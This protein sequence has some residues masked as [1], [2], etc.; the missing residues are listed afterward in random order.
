MGLEQDEKMEKNKKIM[1]IMPGKLKPINLKTK[2]NPVQNIFI[3]IANNN[4]NNIK[5]EKLRNKKKEIIN[6][7][8]NEINEK[9]E[10]EDEE[11]VK[12]NGNKED[13]IKELK[14]EVDNENTMNDN[15]DI[16]EE[17]KNKM[18]NDVNYWNANENY[19]SE[20]EREELL[21]DL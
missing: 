11:I 17:A 5:L 21:N 18:F 20:E 12:K 10:D 16:E 13:I 4:K 15:N 3:N 6:M 2:S 7:F 1:Y 19:L 9:N 14:K 8:N